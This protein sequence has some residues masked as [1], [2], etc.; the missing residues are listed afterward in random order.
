VNRI[1]R[2]REGFTPK[3]DDAVTEEEA[4][5]AI[6]RQPYAFGRDPYVLLPRPSTG[7]APLSISGIGGTP[8]NIDTI[9]NSDRYSKS[10]AN[11]LWDQLPR[12]TQDAITQIARSEGGRSGRARW[13]RAVSASYV[14]SRQGNPMSP[15]D[16][17]QPGGGDA[18]PTGSRTGGRTR[19]GRTAAYTGPV[20]SI[21]K[22]AESDIRALADNVAIEILGRGAT[23]E[24][25]EKITRRMRKAE[26]QQPDV[27]TQQ[28][29]GR[30]I[31]EQGLSSQGREDILRDVLSKNPDFQ[32]YQL[33][34][35]VMDAMVNFVNKKKAVAGD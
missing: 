4:K 32:Q 2:D 5:S 31:T 33:D 3:Y 14:S 28:G 25:I 17:L 11:A 8:L 1:P 20:E 6:P 18:Q 23:A 24:E 21:T 13:E 19:G 12:E 26:M 34:T 9:I 30:T 10:D 15:W 27:R 7:A 35:T 29:P 16:F 22:L